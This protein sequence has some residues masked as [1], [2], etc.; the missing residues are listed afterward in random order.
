MGTE[1]T[2]WGGGKLTHRLAIPARESILPRWPW[3]ASDLLHHRAISVPREGPGGSRV[4]WFSFLALR[5]RIA[6]SSTALGREGRPG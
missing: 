3:G 2:L 5:A 4:T 1:D 6:K